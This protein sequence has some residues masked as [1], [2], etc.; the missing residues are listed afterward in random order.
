MKSYLASMVTVNVVEMGRYRC[1]LRSDR[2]SICPR[3]P[4]SVTSRRRVA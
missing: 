1:R 4:T 2:R 3:D